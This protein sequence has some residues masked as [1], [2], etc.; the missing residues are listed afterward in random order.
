M[1]AIIQ[2]HKQ[3]IK[4]LMLHGRF[5]GVCRQ[6]GN[7]AIE[8]SKTSGHPEYAYNA[9]VTTMYSYVWTCD[10]DKLHALKNDVLHLLDNK[11]NLLLYVHAYNQ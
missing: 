6:T 10:Y 8:L 4:P 9:C 3:R 1:M 7:K 5:N 11:F 2:M